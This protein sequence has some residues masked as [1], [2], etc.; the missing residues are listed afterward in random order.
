MNYYFTA[1][2]II[3]FFIMALD[4]RK[5]KRKE[6]RIS[7]AMLFFL[8]IIGG[9]IGGAAAMFLLHHKNRKWYFRWGFIGISLLQIGLWLYLKLRIL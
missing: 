1:I 2:N 3:T 8:S 7:E 5:A 9:A 6:W 4:K